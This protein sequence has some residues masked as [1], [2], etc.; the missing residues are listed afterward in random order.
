MGEIALGRLTGNNVLF[1][2][3]E[4]TDALLLDVAVILLKL[5]G[6]AKGYNGQTGVIV[7]TGLVV[8]SDDDFIFAFEDVLAFL[9]V[10]IAD[11][12]VPT[13]CLE[14]LAQQSCI[15]KTVFHDI[16]ITVEPQMNEI[17]ILRDDLGARAGEVQGI[18]FFC[19]TKIVQLKDQVFGKVRLVTPDDPAN[20]RIDKTE[21]VP[22][23][24]DRFHTRKLE[25]PIKCLA[26]KFRYRIVNRP[27]GTT[28]FGV[29]KGSN[30]TTAGGIHMDG[31][32]IP[33]LRL[34][35]IQD[36]GNL[37]HWLVVTGIG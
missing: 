16:S 31:N 13:C 4:V 20:A 1:P 36:L 21:L 27:F 17:I 30:K 34:V 2:T 15:C 7:G 3:Q 11:T 12:N 25:V 6:E 29:G 26:E 8:F 18:G 22:R 10:D 37:L 28:D 35:F 5:V 24:V 23:G 19:S 32:I 9:P 33:S 14:R